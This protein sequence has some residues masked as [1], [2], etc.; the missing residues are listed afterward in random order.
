MAYRLVA[1]REDAEDIAQEA[2]LRLHRTV[3]GFRGECR[4]STWLYRTVS[5][6]AVDH[7]KKER[8]R[9]RIFF[10]QR[11]A[12]DEADPV[13]WVPDPTASP[14]DQLLA[15]EALR[16]LASGLKTLSP[17]QRAIFIL[18]HQEEL[19]LKEIADILNLQLGTVKSHL[20]RAVTM[21]GKKLKDLE[22]RM[23]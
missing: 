9:R 13:E 4:V 6:L 21:L 20:H 10:F 23:P 1:S 14:K 17:K 11:E 12:G 3:A 16:R 15:R 18:R 8:R 19:P 2:F 5:R 7:L 22:E